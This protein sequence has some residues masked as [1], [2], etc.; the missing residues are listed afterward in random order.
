MK[1][2][3]A[4]LIIFFSTISD[5]RSEQFIEYTEIKP[6]IIEKYDVDLL[7]Y[8]KVLLVAKANS[9][10]IF[11][12]N[13]ILA[14][15]G[16]ESSWNPKAKSTHGAIGLTQIIPKY[17]KVDHKIETQVETTYKILNEYYNELKD[18]NKTI[19]AY[20][21]GLGNFKQGKC[22]KKYLRKFNKELKEIEENE[23]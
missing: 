12:A 20:N 16:I 3:I 11:K 15:I 4:S 2:I 10:H 19:I 7:L 22:G 18:K 14:I 1:N 21:C 8:K 6:Y 9:G 13:D 5:I 17:W 23:A